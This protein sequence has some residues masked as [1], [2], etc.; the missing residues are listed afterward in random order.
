MTTR[1]SRAPSWAFSLYAA[2]AAFATYFC[3]YG[4]RKPFA[5][6]LYEGDPVAGLELKTLFITAQVV[7]YAL[8]KIIGVKVVSE[9]GREGRATAI[10]ACV[11]IA[12]VALV[13]FALTPQ[14]YSAVWMVVNGLPLGMIW[15]LVFGYLE[16]R[17]V[18]DLL[19][20]GLCAS[21]ILASGVVKAVGRWFIEVG[22]PEIWMPALTG[23]CF[24]IPM[25]GF[26]W[27]LAQIPAPNGADVAARSER[28]PMDAAARKAF[29]TQTWQGLVPLL[30]AYVALT[31]FRDF[32]DNFARELWDALGY[33]DAP[34]ILAL[35]EVPIAF[36]ALLPVVLVAFFGS[37]RR[38]MLFLYGAMALG[39]ALV[40]GSTVLW[41][42]ELIGP[43]PWM[44]AVG[45]GA[46]LAYVP[47]N[48][49]LFDRLVAALGS[50][51]TA[52]FLIQLADALGYVGSVGLL[53]YKNYGQAELS[54]LAFFEGTSLGLAVLCLFMFAVSGVWFARR[55]R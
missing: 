46:Y 6:G 17:T 40:G 49:A 4:L 8:S 2:S 11:G 12:E 22:V 30:A 51:A 27:M 28:K 45:L 21:F 50:V 55:T 33:A 24:L 26:T 20:A 14:P 16:G 3:M 36:G 19:G 44:V 13:L 41:Q 43:A 34:E 10:L 18:S 42:L 25:L 37:N 54:W 7:G 15:G 1:L 9:V 39:A 29:V 32:R 23:I 31:A 35:S 48:C 47:Y 52:A 53:F 38:A 5:V